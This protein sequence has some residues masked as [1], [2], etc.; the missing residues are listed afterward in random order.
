MPLEKANEALYIHYNK[1][2]EEEEIDLKAH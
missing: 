2:I 1:A